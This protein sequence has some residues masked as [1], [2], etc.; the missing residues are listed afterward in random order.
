VK[1]IIT[2][3]AGTVGD[4]FTKHLL[5][6]KHTVIGIDNN[7]WAVASYPDYKNLTK[8]LGDFSEYADECD[9]LIHCAAYKHVDLL[10]SNPSAAHGNNVERTTILY[11]NIQGG[12]I[13]FI[14]T[15]KSVEPSSE[16]G[17][18]KKA[19]EAL[20]KECGGVIARMGNILGSTGSV[21]PRWEACLEKGEPLPITDLRMRR[22]LIPANVAVGKIMAILPH[23]KP[24]DVIVPEMGSP[25]AL[26]DMVADFLKKHGK[27]KNYPTRE[28]GMRP[29]EKLEEKLFWDHERPA[30][31]LP[32]G[33]IYRTKK[34]V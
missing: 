28:I 12:Q 6:D 27:P 17:E 13:L 20:T 8:V 10:E 23:A 22:W 19:G 14:S 4:A 5:R 1:V 9:L 30:V 34:D 7:E 25:V 33:T 11:G 29:G 3:F 24:G 18:S 2:G 26:S 15:D 21:I 32:E 31:V 16:Y